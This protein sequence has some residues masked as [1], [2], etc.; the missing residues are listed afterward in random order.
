[1]R[2]VVFAKQALFLTVPDLRG[3]LRC[4]WAGGDAEEGRRI[5]EMTYLHRHML[6]L[7]IFR[8]LTPHVI[9]SPSTTCQPR[10]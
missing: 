6:M 8:A 3:R 10:S 1:V 4:G 7:C 2:I 5:L 9:G